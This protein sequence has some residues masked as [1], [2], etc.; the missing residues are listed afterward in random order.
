MTIQENIILAPY[1]VFKIGG[2]AR[3]FCEVQ[4][5]DDIQEAIL[6]AKNLHI[7]FF[8]FGAGSNLLVSDDGFAGLV[9]KMNLREMRVDGNILRAD[10]GASMAQALNF[11]INYGLGGLEWAIGI[12]GTIGGSIFG[13]AGCFESETKDVVDSINILEVDRANNCIVKELKNKDCDFRYRHSI[14]KEH[15]N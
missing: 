9:I 3:Y 15:P 4:N 10:A 6:F 11:S 8:V 7:S 2:P 1:T 12:P 5:L 14:F 13:N